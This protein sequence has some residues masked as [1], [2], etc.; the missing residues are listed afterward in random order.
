MYKIRCSNNKIIVDDINNDVVF[1][2]SCSVSR[3]GRGRGVKGVGTDAPLSCD[4]LARGF[5]VPRSYLSSSSILTRGLPARAIFSSR[6]SHKM[7]SCEWVSVSA[8]FW[9]ARSILVGGHVGVP[10]IDNIKEMK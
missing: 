10:D 8:A 2:G 5:L 3:G 1:N 9:I 7:R 6:D 4:R